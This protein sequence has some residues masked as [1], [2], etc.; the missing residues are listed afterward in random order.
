MAA[1]VAAVAFVARRWSLATIALLLA[2]WVATT[3][4]RDTF[5]LSL[6]WNFE[7]RVFALD[8]ISV[9]L[10]LVALVRILSNGLR[11]IA[12]GLVLALSVLL[13]IH[14][15]RGVLEYNVQTAVDE[16][17]PWI[18]FTAPLLYAAT[19]PGGWD[20]RAWK[21]LAATG[22]LLAM[23]AVVYFVVEGV[24]SAGAVVERGG[25]LSR[26]T[27]I[28]A[29][30]TLLIMQAVV[31]GIAL[32]WPSRRTA[33]YVALGA[34]DVVLFLQQRTVWIAGIA[35]LGLSLFWWL[36][37]RP[38]RRPAMAL[39]A[40][41][42]ILYA[43][44]IAFLVIPN[45]ETTT[46]QHS[47]TVAQ[48]ADTGTFSW[49]VR[50]WRELLSRYHSP[51]VLATGRPAGHTFDRVSNGAITDISPHNELIDTYVRFGLPG[52]LVLL[53][54]VWLLWSRRET[55][56]RRTDI[57][58]H[59]VVLLIVSQLVF[60]IAYALDLV[61]GLILGILVS[62]A[63]AGD[64]R[65]LRTV[66]GEHETSRRDESLPVVQAPVQHV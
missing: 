23:T 21:L 28:S 5:N 18:Y 8:L 58:E 63:V 12:V 52:V 38:L 15:A 41:G 6:V 35:M 31:I 45:R 3:A 34:A 13:V 14:I 64:V 44:S 20:R 24:P 50:G 46:I 19:V 61:Q 11:S 36:R 55:V 48:S 54:L 51:G 25:G 53:W 16:A 39:V 26:A 42:V 49:R 33:P 37:E 4:L 22:V 9:S 32:R 60:G 56:A 65:V 57:A 43:A 30:G 62:G 29:E 27:S 7:V 66:P 17:R 47:G 40:T 10:A 59:A 2:V 1:V